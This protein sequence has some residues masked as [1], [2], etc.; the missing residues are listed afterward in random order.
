[1]NSLRVLREVTG[2]E[3]FALASLEADLEVLEREDGS[4]WVDN[5]SPRDVGIAHAL[6]RYG[7][8]FA[9]ADAEWNFVAGPYRALDKAEQA[10]ASAK[11][12][13]SAEVEVE[14]D[15][16]IFTEA[17]PAPQV[18]IGEEAGGVSA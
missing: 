17:A 1:M 12:T 11:M 3:P 2:L 15:E 7:G 10:R 6:G 16:P 5:D 13:V 9:L 14:D 8:R 18:Q 4:K